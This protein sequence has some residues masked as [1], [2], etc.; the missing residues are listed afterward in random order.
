M[1]MELLPVNTEN[2][3]PEEL[4]LIKKDL[5]QISKEEFN[6]QSLQVRTYIMSNQNLKNLK[7]GW[8]NKQ[9]NNTEQ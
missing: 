7:E 5:S 1:N 8:K 6:K 3:S 2:F 9:T 4:E